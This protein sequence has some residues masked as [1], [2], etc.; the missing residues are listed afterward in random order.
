MAG[1]SIKEILQHLKKTK[2]DFYL[3]EC[4]ARLF[5]CVKL[6][7]VGLNVCECAGK[8]GQVSHSCLAKVL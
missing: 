1:R 2:K 8:A 6:A 5:V 7:R 4:D 3:V